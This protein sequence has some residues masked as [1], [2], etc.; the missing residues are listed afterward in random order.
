VGVWKFGNG[1]KPGLVQAFK[2]PQP[3]E[4][5]TSYSASGE[6]STLF[7][8]GSAGDKVF[9]CNLDGNADLVFVWRVVL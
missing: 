5:C 6:A 9:K 3:L 8:I 2:L 7:Y 4:F 1:G